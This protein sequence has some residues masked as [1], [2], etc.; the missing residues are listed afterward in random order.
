M[1]AQKQSRR[2]ALP[3]QPHLI[4]LLAQKGPPAEEQ[5][6]A[7]CKYGI[8]CAHLRASG[9]CRMPH[10]KHHYLLLN[11]APAE[12]AIEEEAAE[13]ERLSKRERKERKVIEKTISENID[14]QG[15]LQREEQRRQDAAAE[16]KRQMLE[17]LDEKEKQLFDLAGSL[18]AEDFF[19]KLNVR[20]Q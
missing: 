5:P 12:S 7:E 10:R 17:K 15:L 11:L 2:G 4:Q 1:L 19:G 18:T 9:T 14:V 13:E 3:Q 6:V 16:A 8:W 20:R